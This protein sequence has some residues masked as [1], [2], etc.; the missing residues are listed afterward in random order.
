[1]PDISREQIE[2]EVA[3][4]RLEAQATDK[5][6]AALMADLAQSQARVKELEQRRAADEALAQRREAELKSELAAIERKTTG[7]KRVASVA[8]DYEQKTAAAQAAEQAAEESDEDEEEP[9]RATKTVRLCA[10]SYLESVGSDSESESDDE[11]ELDDDSADD[12]DDEHYEVVTQPGKHICFSAA[13][14][15]KYPLIFEDSF[16]DIHNITDVQYE[17]L[18]AESLVA[19]PPVVAAAMAPDVDTVCLEELRNEHDADSQM[20]RIAEKLLAKGMPL[21]EQSPLGSTDDQVARIFL[22]SATKKFKVMMK[23]NG[24]EVATTD[25]PVRNSRQQAEYTAQVRIVITDSNDDGTGPH[26]GEGL[27]NRIF[28]NL[29]TAGHP[30]MTLRRFTEELAIFNRAMNVYASGQS[31]DL[32]AMFIDGLIGKPNALYRWAVAPMPAMFPVSY[33]SVKDEEEKQLM[34]RTCEFLVLPRSGASLVDL[35]R[36]PGS[37]L[38]IDALYELVL[39]Q[40]VA[41]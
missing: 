24:V 16:C 4:A 39:S 34:Q 19:E 33:Y 11:C 28:V 17:P 12:E 35:A 26:I 2:K 6:T 41:C 10:A 38:S 21:S 3:R 13:E 40:F 37:A 8:I 9:S 18:V 30:I 7:G 29:V 32:R 1:M 25:V 31:R 27:L 14:S 5:K 22:P 36:K 20:V 23:K 15:P